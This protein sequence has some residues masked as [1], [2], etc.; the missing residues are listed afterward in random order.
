MQQITVYTAKAIHTMNPSLP[1]A[2]AVAVSGDR[3]IEVGSLESLSPWLDAHPHA[4][5]GRFADKV[6]MPGFIDPHLHPS[7][8]ALLLPMHFITAMDWKLPWQDVAAVR[9]QN[10]FIDRLTQIENGMSD[11]QEPLFTW[12][13]HPIWHGE[14]DRELINGISRE[15]PVIVWHRGFHSLVVNDAAVRWMKLEE[16]DLERHPQI[17]AKT[18]KFYETG[19]AVAFRSMNPYLLGK[20]RFADGMAKLRQC[21]HHGGQTTIGDMAFGIFDTEMEWAQQFATLEQDD[22]PFRVALVPVASGLDGGDVGPERIDAVRAL[23]K[24]NTHRLKFAN[25]VKMFADGGLFSGLSQFGPPGRID[26]ADGE[27]MMPPEIFE[28][29]ARLFW[30]E[31]FQIHVH[32][33]AEL[34]VELALD[35]LEKLQ[36]ER[37]RFNHRFT[38]EHF[39]LSTQE[40]VRRM[41]SLGALASVNPNYVF[42]LGYAYWQ[43][44]V[45]FER[46]S[47]MSRCGSLVRHNI[48]T[49]LHS[50]FTMAPARPLNSAWIAANRIS[51][52]GGTLCPEECLSL[53]DALKAITIEA[54]Y[55]LDMEDEIGSIRAGKKADFTILEQDPYE[56]GAE[57]L[58]DIPIWGTVFEG[59]PFPIAR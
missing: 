13:H 58:K 32:C 1:L 26:G 41:A 36:W 22:T 25:H 45:G 43:N 14:M 29:V 15:R 50:D 12:G 9:G 21:V 10:A 42:E 56:V 55:I 51:E 34:G 6:I 4:I 23:A 35:T 46:A 2:T 11:P 40:Q 20:A 59:R 8:A 49:T 24:R 57:G 54:A 16:A 39:G 5:D 52:N 53:Y 18:G 3:I 30:N 7:M 44:L 37:P 31:G 47:Q 33:S 17:D 27:W 28:K 48:P 19:L 38:F